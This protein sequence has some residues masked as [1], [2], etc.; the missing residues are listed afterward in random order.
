MKV[1]LDAC[2]LNRPFDDQN[3]LRVRLETEAI[4]LIMAK[5]NRRD[6]EW[7][8]SEMLVYEITRTPDPERLQRVLLLAL[9]SHSIVETSTQILER[10]E[11]LE[12]VGF[13]AY[14]AIHL[15]SAE[16]AEVDIFVTTDDQIVKIATR[17]KELLTIQVE[18]PIKWLEEVLK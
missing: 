12:Q 6:W 10:A 4:L 9:Q 14:D 1:Y 13:D 15:A 11:A 2:C 7:V 16:A 5:L 8:G 18:N 17:N 3:R